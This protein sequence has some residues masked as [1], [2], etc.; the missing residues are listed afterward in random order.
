MVFANEMVQESLSSQT[1]LSWRACQENSGKA[2]FYYESRLL[3]LRNQ[4][5]IF[6]TRR[7]KF[8][9]TSSDR[10]DKLSKAE[11]G[12]IFS[13]ASLRFL[14]ETHIQTGG[15]GKTMQRSKID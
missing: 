11:V 13:P 6:V 15:L 8:I 14:V 3:N 1:A 12:A 10:E 4:H 7:L 2:G 9:C 5:I